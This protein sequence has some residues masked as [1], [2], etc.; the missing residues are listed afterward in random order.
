MLKVLTL[1]L[2]HLHSIAAVAKNDALCA[3]QSTLACRVQLR[4][5]FHLLCFNFRQQ[6]QIRL[7][8]QAHDPECCPSPTSPSPQHRSGSVPTLFALLHALQ[9]KSDPADGNQAATQ[10]LLGLRCLAAVFP[11][12]QYPRSRVPSATFTH[13]IHT[14]YPPLLLG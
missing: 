8:S 13:P 4:C 6:C 11:I 5:P 10:S 12:E 7:F 14:Q 3:I 9:P 2:R 1:I